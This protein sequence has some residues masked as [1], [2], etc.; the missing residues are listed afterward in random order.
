MSFLVLHEEIEA[1]SGSFSIFL[2]LHEET[3]AQGQSGEKLPKCDQNEPSRSGF[4]DLL[5]K[6]FRPRRSRPALGRPTP[7][8]KMGVGGITLGRLNRASGRVVYQL[9]FQP[10]RTEVTRETLGQG[11]ESWAVLTRPPAQVGS[12]PFH[13]SRCFARKSYVLNRSSA[14]IDIMTS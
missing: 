3:G 1:P 5:D 11:C 12:Y 10:R 14:S 2:V 8:R 13:I 7:L 6:G 9:G 4:E